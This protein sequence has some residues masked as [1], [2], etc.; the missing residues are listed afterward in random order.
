[1]SNEILFFICG[2][3]LALSA[4]TVSIIGLRVKSFP[5]R[6]MPLV[7]LWFA[8]LVGASTTFAVLHGK[9]DEK[10]H[11]AEYEKAGKEIERDETSGPFE[12]AEAESATREKEEEEAEQESAPSK[13][14]GGSASQGSGEPSGA[15]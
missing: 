5:G 3:A 4:V 8:I 15:S 6:A 7:V 10:A 1:M 2:V 13:S 11:S 9:D 12:S 14:G